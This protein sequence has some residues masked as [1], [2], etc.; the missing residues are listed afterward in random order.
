[1]DYL[2]AV[3]RPEYEDSVIVNIIKAENKDHARL[4]A[5]YHVYLNYNEPSYERLRAL[6]TILKSGGIANASFFVNPFPSE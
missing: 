2:V 3:D 1:M 6:T 4:A 5:Y